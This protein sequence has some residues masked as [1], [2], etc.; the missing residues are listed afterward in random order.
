MLSL[1]LRMSIWKCPICMTMTA[2][3]PTALSAAAAERFC[4]A[5]MPTA[6]GG[7]TP[8]PHLFP[9]SAFSSPL[10]GPSPS[11]SLQLSPLPPTSSP[12]VFLRGLPGHPGGSRGVRQRPSSGSLALLHV[13]AAAAVWCPAAAPRLEPQASGVLCQ[14]QWTGVCKWCLWCGDLRWEAAELGTLPTDHSC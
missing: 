3:S 2:T 5:A 6:A 7:K 11:S 10:P 12:Q 13:P 14:R 9:P 1:C 4:C 8:R